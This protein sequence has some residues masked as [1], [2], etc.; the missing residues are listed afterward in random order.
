MD[1]LHFIDPHMD[2][3]NINHHNDVFFPRSNVREK[4]FKSSYP[5][6]EKKQQMKHNVM[7]RKHH[8]IKQP[9]FDVQ[10]RGRK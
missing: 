2:R 3:L 9:G 10:R 5:S 7:M 8:N 4:T 6:P 1:S